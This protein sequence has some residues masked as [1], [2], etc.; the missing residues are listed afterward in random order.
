MSIGREGSC[1]G[2]GVV[3]KSEINVGECLALI[4]RTTVLSCSNSK[5]KDLVIEDNLLKHGSSWIP[6]LLSLAAEYSSKVTSILLLL[7]IM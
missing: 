2:L 1:D 7:S 3:A 4:P 6:L 5:I